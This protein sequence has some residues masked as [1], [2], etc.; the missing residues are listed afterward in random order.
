MIIKKEQAIVRIIATILTITVMVT[1]VVGCGEARSERFFQPVA[2]VEGDDIAAEEFRTRYID[3]LLDTGLKDHPRQREAF[4]DHLITLKL[5]VREALDAGL[6]EEETYLLEEERVRQK[7][8]VDIYTHRMLYDTLHVSDHELED[9]FVRVNTSLTARHLYER[10]LERANLLYERLQRGE[11]FEAL[12]QEI[13]ADTVLANSGGSVGTFSFDEMD[14]AFEDA[15]YAL[16][17]GEISR[18]VRTDQ[19]YSII[20]VDDRFT[21]PLLTETEFA[22]RK[23]RLERYV[24]SKKRQQV[25]T[26]HLQDLTAA[27]APAFN[28]SALELLLVQVTGQTLVP[29]DEVSRDWL[30]QTVVGFG[31]EGNRRMWTVDT[32]RD[33][34]RFTSEEQRAIVRNHDD[35]E[36]FILGLVV[37][38]EM[39][40][41]AEAANLNDLPEYY[42]AFERAMEDWVFELAWNRH[43]GVIE[44]PEDSAR[45]YFEAYHNEFVTPGTVQVWEIM[46]ETKIEALQLKE[47]L[48][49][50][51]FEL[52]ARAH[53]IR[54]G[55]DA[56]GGDLGFVRADQLG[57]LADPVF[58]ADP[59]EILDPLEVAGRYVLLKVGTRRPPQ[60]ATFEEVRDDVEQRIRRPMAQAHLRNHADALRTRYTVT[61][62]RNVL[63]NIDLLNIDAPEPDVSLSDTGRQNS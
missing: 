60:P 54:P 36:R 21:K 12:A 32:F 19:G 33:R 29:D 61:I 5:M 58:A 56:T 31:P 46:T 4:L 28:E 1:G 8:L 11:S 9:M 49:T 42:L 30:A 7:L 51:H 40:S 27:M 10:T 39:M 47:L 16:Q 48:L 18:P 57:V 38:D 13:F 59:G 3:Y 62:H 34:A 55:A 45:A 63:Y 52:L 37:R 23:D 24:L 2:T 35:M 43:A 14:P 53:S 26:A 6:A 20:Q 41:R 44:V 17:V 15:A 22:E 50:T 25:R